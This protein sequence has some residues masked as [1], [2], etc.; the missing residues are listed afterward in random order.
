MR[1]CL[2]LVTCSPPPLGRSLPP[3][4]QGRFRDMSFGSNDRN[5]S[6]PPQYSVARRNKDGLTP[7]ATCAMAP[8]VCGEARGVSMHASGMFRFI[9]CRQLRSPLK[10]TSPPAR[11]RRTS[12]AKGGTAP[13]YCVSP[14]E[15]TKRASSAQS[16]V[17]PTYL[18][19]LAAA[20]E[21][22]RGVSSDKRPTYKRPTTCVSGSEQM[23]CVCP[24]A[25]ITI[26]AIQTNPFPQ[27]SPP[28]FLATGLG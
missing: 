28:S 3:R 10:R 16:S 7:R 8:T 5:T 6:Q 22:E 25:T 19:P 23:G 13:L 12:D 15:R 26:M 1:S 18:P 4:C 20:E 14:P 27:Q 9:R 2:T 24:V 21:G 11:R 17:V